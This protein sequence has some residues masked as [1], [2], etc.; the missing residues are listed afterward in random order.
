[1]ECNIWMSPWAILMKFSSSRPWQAAVYVEFLLKVILVQDQL[2][3]SYV[4]RNTCAKTCCNVVTDT[5]LLFLRDRRGRRK[6]RSSTRSPPRR[7]VMKVICN[8]WKYIWKMNLI[9][10]IYFTFGCL[11]YDQMLTNLDHSTVVA[12]GQVKI[13]NQVEVE[14]PVEVKDP[15]FKVFKW[16]R[17]MIME[18]FPITSQDLKMLNLFR[19]DY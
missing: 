14:K 2:F 17:Q 15:V 1:M 10:T 5:T 6:S 3:I 19:V 16:I 11:A 13:K 4:V 12:C 9:D 7:F 8:D 18:A